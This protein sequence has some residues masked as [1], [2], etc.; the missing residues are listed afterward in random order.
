MT[1]QYRYDLQ[2]KSNASTTVYSTRTNG[3][4]VSGV[5]DDAPQPR[6]NFVEVPGRDGA[7][8][9]SR[10]VTGSISYGQGKYTFSIVKDFASTPTPVDSAISALKTAI[11]GKSLI[12][13]LVDGSTGTYMPTPTGSPLV[14]KPCEIAVT[15]IAIEPHKV[16]ATV[17]CIYG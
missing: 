15:D 6:Y 13:C 5:K 16:T 11:H 4:V 3:W 9:L 17:E 12:V 10:V 8:N 7:I 14:Y 1:Y 2:F